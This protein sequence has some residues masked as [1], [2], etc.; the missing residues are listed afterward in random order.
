MIGLV[1]VGSLVAVLVV[2]VVVLVR[3]PAER[4]RVLRWSAP[5]LLFLGSAVGSLQARP[6]TAA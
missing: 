1:M 4:S 2:G 3:R 5:A 6:S